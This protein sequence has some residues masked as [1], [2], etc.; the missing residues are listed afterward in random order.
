MSSQNQSLFMAYKDYFPIGAAVNTKTIKTHGDILIKHFNSITAENEMKFESLHPK[1]GEYNFTDSDL[2]YDFAQRN[3]MK[4][5]GH[6]LVWHNQT[7]AWVFEDNEGKE[8]SKE[9]LLK[10]LDEHIYVLANRYGD[11]I[12]C[13]DVANE[14]I[15]DK[16]EEYLRDSKW[17]R[18]IGEDYIMRAFEMTH[19]KLPNTLLFYNDYNESTPKKREK[20][21]RLVSSLKESGTP[22][23]GVGLQGHWNIFEPSFDEIK[24]SFEIYASLGL[25][26]QITEMDI[27]MFGFEDKRMDL[28]KPTA[29]MI[30]KQAMI[31]EKAFRMFREYKEV[32]NGVT[33][34]GIADDE[35]WLDNFPVRGRKNWPLLFDENHEPKEAFY[36]ILQF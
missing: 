12:Y 18:I 9:A 33:L 23:H 31:Y 15:E 29:G 3:N 32:I 14:V 27:S 21:V 16:E 35:N 8:I 28:T 7:P 30:E 13:W 2:I 11:G 24:R 26:V 25:K 1:A 5:R 22:I 34:W 6:T 4:L 10:T 19:K 36:R 17:L 20:I